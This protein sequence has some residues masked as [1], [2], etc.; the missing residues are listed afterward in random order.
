M[1]TYEKLNEI[2]FYFYYLKKKKKKKN[3]ILQR[4]FCA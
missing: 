3:N 1:N 4:N 2:K